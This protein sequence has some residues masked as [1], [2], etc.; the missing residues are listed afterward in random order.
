MATSTAGVGAL[1][2]NPEE[3]QRYELDR[4]P[5][6]LIVR[7]KTPAGSV[8]PLVDEL[9]TICERHFTYRLV[10][11]MDEVRSL[12]A[13][14]TRKFDELRERLGQ[15]A[16][17]LRLCGMTDDCLQRFDQEH[18]ELRNHSDRREAVLASDT[19]ESVIMT[20]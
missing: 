6:W 19:H 2:L 5:N 4:G 20:H 16:G 7:L 15:R 18:S 3:E 10:V 13:E 8:E 9:W 14:A 17:A 1:T 12:S 11:E